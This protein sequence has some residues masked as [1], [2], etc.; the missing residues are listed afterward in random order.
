MQ[1]LEGDLEQQIRDLKTQL[2]DGKQ[3]LQD[4]IKDGSS[5]SVQL[6]LDTKNHEINTLRTNLRAAESLVWQWQN[7]AT[8]LR[9]GFDPLL[10]ANEIG[11]WE[12]ELMRQRLSTAEKMLRE[13]EGN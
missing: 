3:K 9:A 8:E 7:R 11:D 6:Y 13:L 1:T 12:S 2:Q 5:P 10:D 4:F